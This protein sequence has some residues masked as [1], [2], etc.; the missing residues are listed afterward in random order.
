MV[1][2]NACDEAKGVLHGVAAFEGDPAHVLH[3]QTSMSWEVAEHSVLVR[4]RAR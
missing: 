4:P 1:L 2:I 3:V